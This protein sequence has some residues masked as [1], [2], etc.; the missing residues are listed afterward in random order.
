VLLQMMLEFTRMDP[1][2]YAKIVN[3]TLDLEKIDFYLQKIL[4]FI[5]I[6]YFH[7]NNINALWFRKILSE[8]WSSMQN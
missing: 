3:F 1:Q 5:F 4:Y 7:Q 8:E 6:D 2:R